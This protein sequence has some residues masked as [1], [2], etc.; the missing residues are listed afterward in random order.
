MPIQ[1][2]GAKAVAGL[3]CP[4]C[5]KFVTIAEGNAIYLCCW[6]NRK[7]GDLPGVPTLEFHTCYCVEVCGGGCRC[8]CHEQIDLPRQ[9]GG[10]WQPPLE[11][12]GDPCL[13]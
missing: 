9:Q 6:Y 13:P 2:P 4:I 8:P 3:R 7:L 12:E 5:R 11:S 1:M 10:I